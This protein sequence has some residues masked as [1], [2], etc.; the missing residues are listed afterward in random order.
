MKRDQIIALFLAVFVAVYFS[1]SFDL[2]RR[3]TGVSLPLLPAL[4]VYAAV[5]FSVW[6]I[7][8]VAVAGGLWLDSYSAAPLGASTAALFATGYFLNRKREYVMHQLPFARVLLGLLVGALVP[9]LTLAVT[10]VNRTPAANPGTVI[11][12]ILICSLFTAILTP[13]VFRLF[14]RL[15]RTFTFRTAAEARFTTKALRR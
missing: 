7:T 9:T 8:I 12:R 15:H 10:L 4:L 6:G 11:F 14:G 5:Q 1:A 13:L 2:P 3:W